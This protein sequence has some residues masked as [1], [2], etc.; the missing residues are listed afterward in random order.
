MSRVCTRPQEGAALLVNGLDHPGG[1]TDHHR[2]MDRNGGENRLDQHRAANQSGELS[3]PGRKTMG[4]FVH[5]R[6]QGRL[7]QF[8]NGQR[9]AEIGLGKI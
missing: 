9:N 3:L 1:K 4:N 2:H 6:L 7:R 5:K 8:A